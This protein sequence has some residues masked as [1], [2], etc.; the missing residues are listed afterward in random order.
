[1]TLVEFC[2]VQVPLVET[3]VVPEATGLPLE[4]WVTTMLRVDPLGRSV[5]PL[6]TGLVLSNTDAVVT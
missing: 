3:V 4:V 1:M 6:S 5:T 2:Q